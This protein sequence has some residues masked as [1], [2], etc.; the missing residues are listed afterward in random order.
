[1][2][3][4]TPP[5]SPANRPLLGILRSSCLALAVMP[6]LTVG[7]CG[8]P[9]D[10]DQ[11]AETEATV[12]GSD[13]L[14]ARSRTPTDTVTVTDGAGRSVLVSRP[15]RRVIPLMPSV[16]EWIIAMGGSGRLVARTD[17][18]D[19]PAVAALPSVGGGLTPSVEW[20]AA[21]RPD[22]VVAWPDAPSRSLVARLEQL[23]IPVYTAPSET[24]EEGLRTA[25]DLG[26]ILGLEAASADAV[27]EVE[28]GL[29]AVSAAV[30][31]QDRRKVLF[32]IGL[33]PLIAAGPGTFVDQLLRR[34]GGDN[35]LADLDVRWPQLS[36]EEVLRRTPDVIVVASAGEHRPIDALRDRPG[37]RDLPAV[38]AGRVYAV[39]PDRVNRPGPGM[40]EAAA[41]LARLIH[42]E[43]PGLPIAS[44]PAASPPP[45]DT[46]DPP[47][48]G[49]S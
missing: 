31:D 35:V 28:A 47:A 12:Q 2:H 33:D 39:D 36:L 1:M 20:M 9:D 3:Q 21:R 34:A 29:E 19:D 32:L 18:D 30:A 24:V 7:A 37:W 4:S 15:A 26:T 8:P 27:A 14:A 42:G 22:L 10:P 43:V 23:G 5:G 46:T 48:G 45:A 44:P 11:A 38:R 41:A 6:A 13:T 40:D 25:R 17:F 16:T 49:P